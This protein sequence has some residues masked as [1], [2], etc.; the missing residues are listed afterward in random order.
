MPKKGDCMD[1]TGK[2]F[3]R[4]TVIRK[5]DPVIKNGCCN[6]V[7]IC[8]CDCGTIRPVLQHSLVTGRSKS[9]GCY[10]RD[11]THQL[12]TK[13]GMSTT[14]IY[15]IWNSMKG[16]CLNHNDQD[17]PNYGGRGISVCDEWLNSFEEF[18]KWAIR[19]GYQE[20]KT[21]KG[22]NILTLDRIDVNGDYEPTNCRFVTNSVQAKNKRNAMTNSERYK[23]CPICGKQFEVKKR[24]GKRTC[25]FDCGLKMRMITVSKKEYP[26]TKCIVCGKEFR[27]R[28][29]RGKPQKYCSEKC[30]GIDKSPFLE[31]NGE[32][33]R[34]IEWEEI[35]GINSD[36][37]C[38]RIR[39]GWSVERALKT[40]IQIK[41]RGDK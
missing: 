40:P 39:N 22:V 18:Y 24:K 10:S 31:M 29:Y 20:E 3:G 41:N 35:T 28:K 5:D 19:N 14:R 33:H 1:I 38:R 26:K 9:C 23:I 34:V 7:W 8:K 4:W 11:K 36:A 2:R 15:G 21:D 6:H 16:R 37:I 17:Y 30:M 32:R 25:S 13:H 12:H 27:S